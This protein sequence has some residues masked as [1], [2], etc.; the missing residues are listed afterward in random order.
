MVTNADKK[1]ITSNI[2]TAELGWLSG[3]SNNIQTQLDGKAPTSHAVNAATYGY[4]TTTNAGHLRVSTGLQVDTGS[5]SVVYGT[6][7]NTACEG[8]DDRLSDSRTPSAHSLGGVA[9]SE[10]TLANLNSKISNATLIS[11]TDGRLSD[12]REPLVHASDKHSDSYE[13]ANANIQTHITTTETPHVT[14]AE[15]TDWETAHTHSTTTGTPHVTTAEKN[16][17]DAK[18]DLALGTTS[19]TAH[20]GDHGASAYNHI[21]QDGSSHTFIDQDIRTTASPTFVKVT[22]GNS[23]FEAGNYRITYNSAEDSLDFSTIV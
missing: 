17:W 18:S 16:I 2:T 11:T 21:T 15:K 8:D 6:S 22:T 20:R 7:A 12:A 23:G 19:T 4:G 5:I 3:V 10:D 14:T 9:H 1:V 13:P